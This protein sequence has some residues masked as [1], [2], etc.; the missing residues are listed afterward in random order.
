MRLDPDTAQGLLRSLRRMQLVGPDEE[1]PMTP[2]AGG[3]SSLIVRVDTVGSGPLCLKRALPQ[4]KVAALW[5]APV[6]RN[7]AE[8]LW[9]Q[10]AGQIAPL[11]V[12][13]ILG[14]DPQDNSFAMTYLEPADYPVWKQQ[15]LGGVAVS[16]TATASAVGRL[17]VAIHSA[18]AGV[19]AMA[20]RFA[21]DA[22]F[23]ALRLEPYFVETARRHPECAAVLL[24]LVG[25][26]AHGKRALVHGDVS[27]KNILVGPHGPVLLDAE[28]AWYGDPAFDLAFCLNHLLLKSVQRPQST[29]DYLAC[30]NAM[31]SS[32]L[33]HVG[34]EPA[35]ELEQRTAALLAA[36]LLARIDGKSPVEYITTEADRDRV[37]RAAVPMLRSGVS[38]LS[39]LV[40]RWSTAA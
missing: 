20:E 36:L 1:A 23:Y 12:P 39:E 37:R 10:V 7:R 34:W 6:E 29:G 15:L 22:N 28:C 8:V 19:A 38:T 5:E 30:F 27:P 14:H 40:D 3:V 4:L 31:A 18:T 16:A 26:T 2:L 17:L 9:M 13:E 24:R 25:T 33:D 21:N 35:A 11:A 32:Y